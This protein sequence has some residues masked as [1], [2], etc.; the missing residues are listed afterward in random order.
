MQGSDAVER[1]SQ[2]VVLV[3][4]LAKLE[5]RLVAHP[6]ALHAMEHPKHQSPY[7]SPNLK[8]RSPQTVCIAEPHSRSSMSRY[9]STAWT[10]CP[11]LA[12]AIRTSCGAPPE[13]VKCGLVV[14]MGL[15]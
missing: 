15:A 10:S 3:L 7:V 6:F 1:T 9:W 11:A 4:R 5:A 2:N 13:V 12:M 14:T 8:S